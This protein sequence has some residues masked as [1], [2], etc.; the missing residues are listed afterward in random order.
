MGMEDEAKIFLITIVQT[1]SLLILWMLVNIII[2][3]KLKLGL[4]E[5]TPSFKNYVYYIVFIVSFFFLLKY[6]IKK[7]K[8]VKT[9]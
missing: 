9:F 6:F 8:K 5:G 4:F 1:V 3:I 7:W 2:G